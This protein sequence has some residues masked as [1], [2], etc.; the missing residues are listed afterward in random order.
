MR[1]GIYNHQHMVGGCPICRQTYVQGMIAD[2]K[3]CQNRAIS[4]YGADSEFF[5]Y[6]D[7]GD[8]S[9]EDIDRPGIRHLIEDVEEG[10]L[11]VVCCYTMDKI[12]TNIDLIMY[13]YGIIRDHGVDFIT[14][15]DGK[16]AMEVMDRAYSSWKKA[17]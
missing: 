4:I 13:V 17:H 10:K 15:A 14:F 5:N 8:Y 2:A 9:P 7:L 1:I 6:T 11:D 16:H 3:M 12:S